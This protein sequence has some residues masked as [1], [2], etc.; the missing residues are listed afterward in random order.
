[1]A[2]PTIAEVKDIK[3]TTLSDDAITARITAAGTITGRIN[4]SCGE[5]FTTTELEEIQ[6]WLA[7]HLVAISDPDAKRENIEALEIDVEHQ[8]GKLG[9]GVKSTF[10]GQTANGLANGCLV[11]LM[12][13][14]HAVVQFA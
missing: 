4:T 11:D 14:K 13:S 7:A 9:E 12:D 1:M 2:A 3:A 10:Y 5:S 8:V 6:L